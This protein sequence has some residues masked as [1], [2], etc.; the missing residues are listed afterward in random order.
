MASALSTRTGRDLLAVDGLGRGGTAV[1]VQPGDV[2]N[3][4]ASV[5]HQRDEAVAFPLASKLVSRAW[6]SRL[7][8]ETRAVQR[9]E[10]QLELILLPRNL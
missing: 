6:L 3:G 8:C 2:L 1:T 4:D 7:P 5:G 9:R 10:S